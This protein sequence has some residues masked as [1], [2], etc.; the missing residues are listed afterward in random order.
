MRA[1]GRDH[2]HDP[3]GGLTRAYGRLCGEGVAMTR[4]QNFFFLA[5]FSL[6]LVKWW[7]DLVFIPAKPNDIYG[8]WSRLIPLVVGSVAYLIWVGSLIAESRRV[9]QP[10]Q[11]PQAS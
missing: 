4:K 11:P 2:G 9:E 3:Q 7:L 1:I 6:V 5:V 8:F 10:R